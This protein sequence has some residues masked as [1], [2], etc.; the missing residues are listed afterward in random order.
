VIHGYSHCLVTLRYI[1]TVDFHLETIASSLS[2]QCSLRRMT[3]KYSAEDQLVMESI[4]VLFFVDR[5]SRPKRGESV[6][7]ESCWHVCVYNEDTSSSNQNHRSR[8]FSFC[9]FANGRDMEE[10]TNCSLSLLLSKRIL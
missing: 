5:R 4:Q 7:P 2:I 9:F 8:L 1:S 10:E 6:P 3:K